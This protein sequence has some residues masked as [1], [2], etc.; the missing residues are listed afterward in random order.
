MWQNLVALRQKINPNSQKIIGNTA[1]L[2]GDKFLRMGFGLLIGVWV[3]RYLGP[4]K[5]GL[6]NYAIAFVSL[7]NVF[8]TLGLKNIVVRDLVRKPLEKGEILGSSFLLKL[9][10]SSLLFIFTVTVIY[11][12]RPDE[13]QTQILVGIIAIGMIF[14]SFDVI[15]LWFQSQVQSK[16]IIL[17]NTSGYLLL[18]IVK[19]IAIKNQAPLIIFA[20]IW[21][22][23][24][25]LAALGLI[26]V[27][28]WQ[29]HLL[30]AW[31]WSFQRAKLLLKESWPLIL[32]Q[33]VI[34]VYLRTDQIMLG[35]MIGESAVGIYAVVVKLSEMLF[36]IPNTVVRSVFPTIIQAKEVSKELYHQRQQ[37]LFTTVAAFSY[38]LAI[39]ITFIS[40]YIVTLIYGENYATGGPI[41]AVLVWSGLF[42]SLGVARS[43]C[44]IAEGLTKFSA[45]TTATGA[46]VNI[47]LNY[48]LIIKYGIMGAAISTVIA[49]IMASYVSHSFYPKTRRIFIE[50]TKALLL[51]GFWKN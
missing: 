40:T 11:L 25:L 29:G 4:E 50:Q 36:L 32:S 26:I 28:Q 42:V 24:F 10:G 21:S 6:L 34:M 23:E 31:R 51:M 30:R 27:Y 49:Q 20:I 44:L 35:E 45:A 12:L 2:L 3:A 43:P 19:I 37:K 15:E 47:I 9:L 8:A 33:L 14:R 46:V 22:G 41:F 16:Y 18:N 38:S 17:A 5:F 1:W 48:F 7:F 13:S 39:P